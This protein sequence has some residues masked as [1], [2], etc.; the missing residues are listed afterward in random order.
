MYCQLDHVI[1]ML[2]GL[3]DIGAIR[4]APRDF[5]FAFSTVLSVPR[6][7]LLLLLTRSFLPRI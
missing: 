6:L 5:L 3:G 4:K 1:G 7:L 2:Y